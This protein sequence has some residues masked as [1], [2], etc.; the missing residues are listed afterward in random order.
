MSPSIINSNC[1]PQLVVQNEPTV[2]IRCFGESP[3]PIPAK[4]VI[5]DFL[6]FAACG[7]RRASRL[8]VFV[9]EFEDYDDGELTLKVT[10]RMDFLPTAR[11][12]GSI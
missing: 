7:S 3:W 10:C 5:L 4:L 9:N 11:L 12:F 8:D 2:E 6:A 1:D